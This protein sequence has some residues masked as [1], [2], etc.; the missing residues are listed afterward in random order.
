VSAAREPHT[1]LE[2]IRTERMTGERLR[3]HDGDALGGIIRDPRVARTLFPGGPPDAAETQRILERHV[4]H[5]DR[6]GF[7]LWLLRDVRSGAVVGRGG[8]LRQTIEGR[9]EVE[10]GWAIVPERWG[11][12][13]ATELARAS[14]ALAWERLG[15]DELISFTLTTN[16][17]SRRVMEKAGL[18]YERDIEHVSLPHVLYR[19]RRC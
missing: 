4:E 5:W 9:D 15:L 3:N 12:G 8:L 10:V 2:E 18:A 7:G 1:G 6:N 11:E 17:A 16:T 13:L 19:L 14:I